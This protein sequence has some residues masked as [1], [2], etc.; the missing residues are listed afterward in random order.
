MP[1]LAFRT[2]AYSAAGEIEEA[3]KSAQALLNFSPDF[4]VSGFRMP[5]IF[6]NKDDSERVFSALRNAGLPD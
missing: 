4:S 3:K 5:H 6:K 2:A 1:A